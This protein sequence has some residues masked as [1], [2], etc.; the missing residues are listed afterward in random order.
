MAGIRLDHTP[1]GIVVQEH[2]N[3]SRAKNSK[4]A[5]RRLNLQ[6]VEAFPVNVNMTLHRGGPNVEDELKVMTNEQLRAIKIRLSEAKGNT[7]EHK[8]F[9]R[10]DRLL[11]SRE[12]MWLGVTLTA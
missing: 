11:R 5:L 3:R 9:T 7:A 4:E 1:S 6:L 10:V 8:L 2:G 12:G